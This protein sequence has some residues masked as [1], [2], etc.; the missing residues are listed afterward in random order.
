MACRSLRRWH[1]RRRGGPKAASSTRSTSSASLLLPVSN[2]T[3]LLAFRPS[4]LSFARLGATMALPWL[5]AIAVEWAVS[6]RF[7]ASDLVGRAEA[8]AEIAPPRAVPVFACTVVVLTLAASSSASVVHVDLPVAAVAAVLANVI[9]NLPAVLL[10]LPAAAA[11]GP[12]LV[13][14]VLVGVNAG[15]NLTYV[16]SLATLL[17]RR[18]LRPAGGGA[19][20]PGVPPPGCPDG[21]SYAARRHPGPM[22][23]VE[24]G[25][26]MQP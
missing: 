1:P 4:G 19:A 20:H 3:N 12:G 21:A 16:G 24:I 14:A 26:M 10:L 17:W 13:L 2:L 9:N 7:F 6:R 25:G 5:A 15:P 22:G 11:V 18:A 23:V 8:E